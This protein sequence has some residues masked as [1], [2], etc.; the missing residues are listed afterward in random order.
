VSAAAA[1]EWELAENLPTGTRRPLDAARTLR[2]PRPYPDLTLD[3]LLTGLPPAAGGLRPLGTVRQAD[4]GVALQVLASPAFRD[5]VV[6][7]P[8]HRHAVCL[9][10]YTCATDAINLQSRGVDAGWRVL[11][12]G[13]TWSGAVELRLEAEEVSRGVEAVSKLA[14]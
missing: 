12:P 2:A 8:P 4:Q 14:G 7:T 11:G 5:V 3:E 1:D 10:P 6:F 9:E 13:Q